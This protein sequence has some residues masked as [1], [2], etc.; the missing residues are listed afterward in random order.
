[1]SKEDIAHNNLAEGELFLDIARSQLQPIP[2]AVDFLH[3]VEAA[4]IPKCLV[5][6][7]PRST[8]V[9]FFWLW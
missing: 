6:N 9:L 7:A 2:G 3:R 5:T 4:A 1:M 8:V